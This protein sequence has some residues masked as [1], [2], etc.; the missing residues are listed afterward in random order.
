MWSFDIRHRV[1]RHGD[2][3]IYGRPKRRSPKQLVPMY[4]TN[5]PH[6]MTR[7]ISAFNTNAVTRSD[8]VAWF[9]HVRHKTVPAFVACVF[10][11]RE[12]DGHGAWTTCARVL[13]ARAHTHRY[14]ECA[15]VMY[16]GQSRETGPVFKCSETFIS[17]TKEWRP[18]R[19]PHLNPLSPFFFSFNSESCS[20]PL[21][22]RRIIHKHMR[23]LCVHINTV[24]LSFFFFALLSYPLNFVGRT[25]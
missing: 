21:N 19:F 14:T 9:R 20:E 25:A 13:N 8:R 5:A 18:P 7:L 17:Q 24:F 15:I 23:A 4:T 11:V 6:R 16:T 2:C 12:R 22:G 3:Y 1:H 10:V